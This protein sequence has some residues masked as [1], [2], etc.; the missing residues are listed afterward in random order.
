M[1]EQENTVTI[2]LGEL[3][4]LFLFYWKKAIVFILIGVILGGGFAGLRYM[5]SASDYT[6]YEEAEK[7]YQDQK[8]EYED[9]ISSNEDSL[10]EY[11]DYSN[12]SILMQIDPQNEQRSYGTVQVTLSEGAS[13][14]D[15]NSAIQN[16]IFSDDF[17][18]EL[19]DDQNTTVEYIK[20]LISVTTN[21]DGNLTI[22]VKGSDSDFT[23]AVY[24]KIQDEVS[25]VSRENRADFVCELPNPTTNT[26]E[27]ED[28]MSRQSTYQTQISNARNAI[29]NA[30]SSLDG[31]TEPQA[32][33]SLKSLLIKYC[34]VGGILFLI[35]DVLFLLL[36]YVRRQ[37]IYSEKSMA[38]RKTK[39]L[40]SYDQVR[41]YNRKYHGLMRF[42]ARKLGL[43]SAEEPASTSAMV[44][45]NLYNFTK[46]GQERKI[47]FLGEGEATDAV[48]QVLPDI[49]K[50]LGKLR[51]DYQLEHV[52]NVLTSPSA[53][54]TLGT[55]EGSVIL[56]RK[57]KTSWNT[58][59]EEEKLL[60]EM[61]VDCCGVV[62]L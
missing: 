8:K 29:S 12:N 13:Q 31:L 44:A 42:A 56:I 43:T 11:L 26:T 22:T 57:G 60:D 30:Q 27:D 49:I 59:R 51:D 37:P 23:E 39:V 19:A 38:G 25:D 41:L 20:E 45:V 33:D 5:R 14:S 48:E 52:K 61:N 50:E 10:S 62:F 28:L 2:D 46:D 3:W 40:G 18:K 15:V 17:L 24:A 54:L 7:N 21:D 55:C 47:A 35:L 4:Y 1:N 9:Y 34:A 6:S 53:R 36:R 58:L 32:P 16:R